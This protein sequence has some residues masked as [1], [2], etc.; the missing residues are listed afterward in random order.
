MSFSSSWLNFQYL[1]ISFWFF[2]LMSLSI[3]F[4]FTSSNRNYDNG[5]ASGTSVAP[6]GD[7]SHGNPLAH[8]SESVNAIDPLNAMEKTINE[9]HKYAVHF[10]SGKDIDCNYW[11]VQSCEIS[12]FRTH[13]R[14][15]FSYSHFHSLT[16]SIYLYLFIS[17][18]IRSLVCALRSH[19]YCNTNLIVN[20]L[21]TKRFDAQMHIL[22]YANI[23]N[24]ILHPLRFLP[25]NGNSWH[26]VF[27]RA[28]ITKDE[29]E[30]EN[31]KKRNTQHKWCMKTTHTLRTHNILDLLCIEL[32]WCVGPLPK[33]H[34]QW[35]FLSF[36]HTTVV[37]VRM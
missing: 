21:Q 18:S 19:H 37:F 22:N 11:H 13:I 9:V 1:L 5:S 2:F 4:M 8:L 3:F 14:T 6:T 30:T 25:L 23:F 32:R 35:L 10:D 36:K 29:E 16:I 33:W 24:S 12:P 20:C 27:I 15:V 7:Y 28:G 26:F 34:A 31:E 17:L